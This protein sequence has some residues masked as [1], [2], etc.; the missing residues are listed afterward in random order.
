MT[1]CILMNQTEG[2]RGP[3]YVCTKVHGPG[4]GYVF[5]PDGVCLGKIENHARLYNLKKI[6]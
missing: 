3:D 4:H 1:M 2:G 6:G 5:S